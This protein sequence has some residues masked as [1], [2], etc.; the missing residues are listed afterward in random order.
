[1][2]KIKCKKKYKEVTMKKLLI[3][4]F[5]T[6]IIAALAVPGYSDGK[7][8]HKDSEKHHHGMD[9]TCPQ[10]AKLN[11]TD[12][13]KAE[14]EKLHKVCLENKKE[15]QAKLT[16]L[17]HEIHKLMAAEKPDK[18]SIYRKI[19]KSGKLGI[20]MKKMC[21]GQKLKIRA[22]LTPEQLKKWKEM[23]TEEKHDHHGH[24]EKC[25]HGHHGHDEEGHH[26]HGEKDHDHD[27]KDHHD[28]Y[29]M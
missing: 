6:V 22:L 29:N 25:H 24:G 18:K 12:S 14:I 26:K 20:E 1:M 28:D 16:K 4:M 5:M 21:I 11:L 17:H 23:M 9:G 15:T 27:E 7:C 10:T 8:K 19:E 2:M 13:Q 3:L